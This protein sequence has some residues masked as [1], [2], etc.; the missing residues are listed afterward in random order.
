[1]NVFTSIRQAGPIWAAEIEA[2]GTPLGF[3]TEIDQ[4]WSLGSCSASSW[5]DGFWMTT[6]RATAAGTTEAE[7]I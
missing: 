3:M 6:A 4:A 1:M 7:G 2:F 5:T